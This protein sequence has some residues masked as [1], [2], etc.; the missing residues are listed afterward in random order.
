[1][2]QKVIR[3]SNKTLNAERTARVVLKCLRSPLE[4]QNT[5]IIHFASDVLPAIAAL[6]GLEGTE[7]Y[8]RIAATCRRIIIQAHRSGLARKLGR[9]TFDILAWYWRDEFDANAEIASFVSNPALVGTCQERCRYASRM[10]DIA[11]GNWLLVDKEE[12]LSLVTASVSI[13]ELAAD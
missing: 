7:D 6:E 8:K 13:P 11:V 1:M 12:G 5:L 3:N 4:G 9:D 2:S 10:L